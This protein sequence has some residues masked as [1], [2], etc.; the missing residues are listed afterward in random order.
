MS[1]RTNISCPGT[2]TM[3]NKRVVDM[4]RDGAIDLPPTFE[5]EITVLQKS[6]VASALNNAGTS[7]TEP[8]AVVSALVKNR[9]GGRP[10]KSSR[11]RPLIVL[12]G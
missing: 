4:A 3:W 9:S 5:T 6:R 2:R 8:G 11:K 12:Q 7:E 10:L 1:E